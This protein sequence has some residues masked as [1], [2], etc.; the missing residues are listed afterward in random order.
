MPCDRANCRH[1]H[2]GEKDDK[3]DDVPE[4]SGPWNMWRIGPI[5]WLLQQH[6]ILNQ[7]HT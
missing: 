1:G 6:T 3:D 4:M 2:P 7:W 5:E